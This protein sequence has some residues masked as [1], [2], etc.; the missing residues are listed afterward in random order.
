MIAAE[1]T[2][3]GSTEPD[4]A[5]AAAVAKACHAQGVVILT[6]GTYGNV[7]RLLP[8]L[9]IGEALLSEG[10]DVLEAAVRAL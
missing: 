7:V 4:S 6:C 5:A 1:F 2:V 8:P 10:M 9:V 3:G